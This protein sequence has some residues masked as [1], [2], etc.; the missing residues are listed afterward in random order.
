MADVVDDASRPSKAIEVAEAG[1][2]PNFSSLDP[3]LYAPPTATGV[4]LNIPLTS[5]SVDAPAEMLVG[6]PETTFDK[7]ESVEELELIVTAI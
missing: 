1:E 4:E 7:S 6:F 2:I 3:P 5:V